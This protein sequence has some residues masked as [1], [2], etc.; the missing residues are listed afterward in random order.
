MNPLPKIQKGSDVPLAIQ[1]TELL[2]KYIGENCKPGDKFF[3]ERKLC[4][5]LE[6]SRVTVGKAVSSLVQ[7]GILYQEH[8]SGTYVAEHLPQEINSIALMV[9]HCDNPFYS[10]IV[11]SIQEEADKKGFQTLLLNS[12]GLVENENISLKKIRHAVSGIIASPAI[13]TA[14]AFSEEL[15]NLIKE[16]FP[17]VVIC[18]TGNSDYKVNSVIPDSHSGGY[19]LTE[20]L[21]K[22][23]YRK[24][25]FFGI[26]E[27]F[28][29]QDIH[30]RFEGYRQALKNNGI[31][32]EKE[33]LVMAEGKDWF[34]GFFNDGYKAAATI[35][36]RI[37]KRTAVFSLGDSS[38]IG[39]MN[40]L[41]EK[42]LKIP[43]DI[44]ICG[45]DDIALAAQ[46]GIELTTVRISASDIGREATR[47][48]AEHIQQK[49]IKKIENIVS[50]VE[51]IVR[52]TA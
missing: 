4:D 3:S 36:P 50:P 38:A 19:K 28:E 31:R 9:Y 1:V 43:E 44:A 7:E 46:W 18:H 5:E 41:R 14:G 8:G 6:L 47:I 10:R 29:R 25:L 27:L 45:F 23:G 11:R 33:W 12:N 20:H 49:H 15:E 34:N 32:F 21:I 26:A 35:I 2:R 48:L 42:G 22:K 17:V 51:L 39:L 13:T 37:E 16:D 30:D 24:I 40:G 52:K